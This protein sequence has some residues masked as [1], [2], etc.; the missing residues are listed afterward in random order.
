MNVRV[1]M[2]L[3]SWYNAYK[4]AAESKFLDNDNFRRDSD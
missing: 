1:K 3:E 4:L 2:K